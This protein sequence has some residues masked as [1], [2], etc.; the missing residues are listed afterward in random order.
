MAFKKPDLV[1]TFR[2]GVE[3]SE[4]SGLDATPVL[5][6]KVLEAV[7]VYKRK[8]NSH[9]VEGDELLMMERR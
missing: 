7:F 1:P 3:P 8:D 2:S 5:Q 6:G 4:L 9:L